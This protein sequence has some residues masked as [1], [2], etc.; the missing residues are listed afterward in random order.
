MTVFSSHPTLERSNPARGAPRPAD[1]RERRHSP[2]YPAAVP[3][4]YTN[5]SSI[6]RMARGGARMKSSCPISRTAA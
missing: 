6:T 1:D 4:P 2:P 5:S 3:A